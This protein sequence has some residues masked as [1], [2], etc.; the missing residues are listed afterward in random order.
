MVLSSN[1]T[2]ANYLRDY[3]NETLRQPDDGPAI[4]ATS[5]L[6]GAAWDYAFNTKDLAFFAEEDWR[7]IPRFT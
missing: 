7:I 5:R 2:T 1:S 6:S 3:T 4:P